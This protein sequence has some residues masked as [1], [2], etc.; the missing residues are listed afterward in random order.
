MNK[1]VFLSVCL[2]VLR[3]GILIDIMHLIFQFYIVEEK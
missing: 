1:H 2:S 3:V